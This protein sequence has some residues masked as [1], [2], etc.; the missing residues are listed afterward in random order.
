M[1][2][3]VSYTHLDVYKRQVLCSYFIPVK[4]RI[5]K[6]SSQNK[7]RYG[8]QMLNFLTS[9]IAQENH[10]SSETSVEDNDRYFASTTCA[11]LSLLRGYGLSLKT[12]RVICTSLMQRILYYKI[13]LQDIML[14]NDFRN[15][16]ENIELIIYF[17]NCF[18]KIWNCQWQVISVM[19]QKKLNLNLV[20]LQNEKCTVKGM[21]ALL[22]FSLEKISET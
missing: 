1:P 19:S 15:Q 9:R 21:K 7:G 14:K 17:K 22:S 6:Y 12:Q 20:H 3:T 10:R 18:P 4:K 2:K 16:S 5:L 8:E 11:I 13:K